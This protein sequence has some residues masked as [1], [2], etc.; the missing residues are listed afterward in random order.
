MAGERFCITPPA[1]INSAN[2]IN[3]LANNTTGNF[4]IAFGLSSGSNLT[5]GNNNI[6]IGNPGVAGESSR[7]RIGTKGTH[8]NTFVAGISGVVVRGGVGVIVDTDGHLGTVVSS[9]RFKEE[10]KPMDKA[11]EAILRSNRLPSATN[12][13]LILTAFHSLALSPKKWRK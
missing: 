7:I 6:D 13:S 5:T 8:S 2:G 11:S 9:K 3:A 1:P 12:T 10:I 4:N